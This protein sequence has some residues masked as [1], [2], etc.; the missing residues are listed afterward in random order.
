MRVADA[1][2][3]TNRTIPKCTTEIG[4]IY[5]GIVEVHVFEVGIGKISIVNGATTKVSIG[6]MTIAQVGIKE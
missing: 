2:I 3:W 1:T 5:A 6:K 4:T